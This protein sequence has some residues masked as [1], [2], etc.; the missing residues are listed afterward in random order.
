MSFILNLISIY[1]IVL[2]NDN[3]KN[4]KIHNILKTTNLIYLMILKVPTYEDKNFFMKQIKKI[5]DN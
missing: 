2:T 5:I 3:N 1:Y 4:N